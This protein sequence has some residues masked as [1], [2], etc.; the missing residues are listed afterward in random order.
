MAPDGST[1]RPRLYRTRREHEFVRAG[2]NRS[3]RGRWDDAIVLIE[4]RNMHT[5]GLGNIRKRKNAAH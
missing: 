5:P 3:L 2:Y 4:H 1:R